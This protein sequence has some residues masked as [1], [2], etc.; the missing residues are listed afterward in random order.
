MELAIRDVADLLNVSVTTVDKWLI[1][2][3][4]PSYKLND[5]FRFNRAE[6]EDWLLQNQPDLGPITGKGGLKQ[7]C[8]FRGIHKGGV[9]SGI[10]GKNKTELIQNAAK[11][12]S[13]A[14]KFD[15][16]LM[17]N[18]LLEREKLMSTALSHGLAV[19]HTR[20]ISSDSHFDAVAV[21]F[22]KEPIDFDAIDG[23]PVHTLFFLFACDEKRHLQILSKIAHL[24][25]EPSLINDLRKKPTKPE[26][27]DIIRKWESGIKSTL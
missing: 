7:F 16:T 21:V 19:P 15:S 10:E 11:A 18:L 25:R 9:F 6:V 17:A 27:L 3:N 26:V 14:L 2:G 23:A 24:S 20:E 4:I 5:E 22:P 12:I 8:L 13:A 1:Q